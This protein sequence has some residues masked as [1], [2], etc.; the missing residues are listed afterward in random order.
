MVCAFYY[1]Q[2]IGALISIMQITLYAES[3][4]ESMI[5]A[6]IKQKNVTMSDFMLK[7]EESTYFNIC[8]FVCFFVY[9]YRQTSWET[10]NT[11]NFGSTTASLFKSHVLII[12][13]KLCCQGHNTV[14]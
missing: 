12:C 4:E 13:P 8:T 5:M 6:Q 2:M 14:I 9:R 10:R 7:G 1:K 11:A 3:F